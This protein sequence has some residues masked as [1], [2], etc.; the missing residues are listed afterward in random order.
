[1][2]DEILLET[3]GNLAVITLNRPDHLN[4]LYGDMLLVLR[5]TLQTVAADP[6]IRAVVLTGAGRGFCAGGDVKMMFQQNKAKGAGAESAGLENMAYDIRKMMETCE[7][8]HEMPK[9]TIAMLRGPTAGGGM[10]IALACDLRFAA[11]DL[12][13]TTAFALVGVSGDFSCS[14]F[15][16]Q[17]VGPAKA[18][19]L[20]FTAKQIN[21]QQALEVGLVNQVVSGDELEEKTLKITN[22]LANGPTIAFNYIKRNINAAAAG[23]ALKE[24]LNLEALHMVRTMGTEDH[25]RAAKAFVE[26][27]QPTFEGR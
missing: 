13:M 4:A 24:V 5:K 25:K 10:G 20:F 23:T 7:L 3:R 8:L 27:R 15:L 18:K 14:Y 2:S 21:A 26:K 17:L 9:P 11:D 6:G 22:Q 1:M 12:I 19:E 16:T